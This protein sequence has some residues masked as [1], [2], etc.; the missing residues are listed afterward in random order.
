MLGS[1]LLPQL[2][3]VSLTADQ[4]STVLTFFAALAN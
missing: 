1:L 3:I 4:F 2:G